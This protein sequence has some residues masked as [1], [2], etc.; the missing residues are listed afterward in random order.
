MLLLSCSLPQVLTR[1]LSTKRPTGMAFAT[2]SCCHIWRQRLRTNALTSWMWSCKAGSIQQSHVT[3]T[4]THGG[5]IPY[6]SKAQCNGNRV[7][8]NVCVCVRCYANIL[9]HTHTRVQCEG[10]RVID[11][12]RYAN[13]LAHT[14]HKYSAK[15]T[16]SMIK[17]CVCVCVRCYANILA[18]T[19]TRGQCKGNRVIDKNSFATHTSHTHTSTVQR[20]QSH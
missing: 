6:Y 11:K 4:H 14:S 5:G 10:N 1:R 13:R 7:D 2:A 8:K 17:I 12:N 3:H 15:E 18:H 16:E 20:K 19:H 9:A